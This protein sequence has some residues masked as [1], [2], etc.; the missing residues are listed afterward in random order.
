MKDQI[1]LN[2]GKYLPRL[3]LGATGIWGKKED[4]S[5]AELMDRQ[6]HIYC[7][8]LMS[9]KCKLF[10]TSGAY[11]HNEEMLGKAVKDSGIER[12]DVL[13]MS[14][15]SNKQQ[16]EGNV[17][18]A[19]EKTLSAL[20]VDY[21]DFYLVHWPQTGTFVQT[22]KEMEK[23]Y[24]EGLIRSIGVCNFHKHH[25]EELMQEATVV[26]A[27]N[28]FEIH[29]LFTQEALI[30]YCYANDIQPIAYSPVGRMHDVLIKS[31]PIYE[32]SQKYQKSAVQIIL[33]WHYQ[34][35]RTAIPRTLNKEHFDDIFDVENFEMT[36]K[37]IA[38]ISSLNENIRLRYNPDTCDFSRL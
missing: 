14:K 2:N 7:H 19:L 28:Q 15:I 11:G 20:G 26:P 38:R 3:G 22:Y 29:P 1:I 36:P 12:K 32:L 16:R 31:R 30:N 24:E 9:G 34:L 35:G 10:D 4:A 6:Y 21:V 18:R 23:L 5:V 13:L 33:R 37:E 25:L 27:V 8:A 17:R